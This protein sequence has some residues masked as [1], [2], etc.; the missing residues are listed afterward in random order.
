MG[1]NREFGAPTFRPVTFA[2]LRNALGKGWRDFRSAPWFGLAFAGFYVLA[3]WIMAGITTATGTVYWL[4]LAAVGFPLLGPFAAVG[5]YEVSRR[6]EAG[7][8][9][10]AREIFG[11]LWQETGRQLPSICAIV[12]LFFLLWFFIGRLIVALFL[13]LSTMTN[14]FS[15]LDVLLTLNGMA[16]LAAGTLVGAGFAMLLF[17]LT[18]LSVPALMD[19]EVDFVTAMIASFTFV[20][21]HPV[22]MVCW[23]AM[24]GLVL[25]AAMVPLLLGLLVALPLFGHATWHL[26]RL[27]VEDGVA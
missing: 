7:E 26:Y 25:F 16:M 18:V 22:P 8:P 5:L 19:R 6:L 20:R 24:I 15:S 14:V 21:R 10:I 1:M 23:A 12:M 13:G 17:M 4:I 11:L 2:T 3:G 9:L 27:L